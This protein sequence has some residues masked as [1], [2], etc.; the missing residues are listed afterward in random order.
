MRPNDRRS[1]T[2]T[3]TEIAEF[4][5]CPE[6]WRLAQLG[7]D[8]ANQSARDAGTVYHARKATAE[9]VAAGSITIGRWLTAIAVIALLAFALYVALTQP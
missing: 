3:A 2:V 6:S 9:S 1:K 8:P 4:V 7:H 5:Y